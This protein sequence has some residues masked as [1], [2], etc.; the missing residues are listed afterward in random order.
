MQSEL[1]TTDISAPLLGALTP[2]LTF[3]DISSCLCLLCTVEGAVSTT[4]VSS[5][6]CDAAE[7]RLPVYICLYINFL[8]F[9]LKYEHSWAA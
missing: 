6:S 1:S 8:P 5:M 4:L 7:H 3:A 2:V 9:Y